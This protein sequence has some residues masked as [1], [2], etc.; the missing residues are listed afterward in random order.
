MKNFMPHSVYI[1]LWCLYSLQGVLYP[2]GGI[3][4]RSLLL[5]LLAWSLYSCYVVN[6][7]CTYSKL[8]AFIKVVNVFLL[9]ATAYGIVLILSGSELYVTEGDYIKT[10]NF[11]Y[12]KSIY[13]SLLPLYVFYD[14]SKRNLLTEKSVRIFAIILFCLA[15]VHYFNDQQ[16]NLI[17]ALEIR[18]AREEFTLNVGY[19]FL[20]LM[21]LLMFWYRKPIFQFVLLLLC[22]IFIVLCMKRGAILI[23]AFCVIYFVYTMLRKTRGTQRFVIA[24][25]TVVAVVVM[26]YVVQDILE[27][28]E[29][30]VQRIEQTLEGDS[31]NRDMI[32]SSYL[33][34]F[35]N[36]QN[37]LRILFGN[38]ANATLVVGSN[39]AH[40]DWLEIAINN[41]LLGLI[42]YILYFVALF[43]DWLQRRKRMSSYY[44][45][46]LFMSFIILFS[47]TLFS[48]SY[49]SI[50]ISQTLA[51]GFILALYSNDRPKECESTE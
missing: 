6:T 2:V 29:Y 25:L 15:I 45:A 4:S 34:H 43:R 30:F 8:P 44:S 49:S 46:A 3:I 22:T 38:G 5:I 21:P 51:M 32:Y 20:H 14:Y 24:F 10:S 31:S 41:G 18:S 26:V 27:T 42:I 28:S 37:P 48:M 1:V 7:K 13:I 9:M 19:T 39:Y 36:E 33:E 17:A 50:D 23:G 40:N 47:T 35:M 16:T 12:L 11:D